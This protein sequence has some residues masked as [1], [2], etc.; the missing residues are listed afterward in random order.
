MTYVGITNDDYLEHHGVKGMKWGVRRYE[1]KGGSYTQKGLSIY[2]DELRKMDASKRK[3]KAAKASGKDVSDAR[4]KYKSNKYKVRKA[5]RQVRRDYRADKGKELYAKGRTITG[6]SAAT[7]ILGTASA[8]ATAGIGHIAQRQGPKVLA[9]KLKN[10]PKARA[11]AAAYLTLLGV[12]AG[13][14]AKLDRDN[15]RLRAYYGHSRPKI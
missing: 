4:V 11:V 5:K 13:A 3:Y 6:N 8:L 7:S 14:G 1:R 15:S 10:D 2:R 9:N 12:T